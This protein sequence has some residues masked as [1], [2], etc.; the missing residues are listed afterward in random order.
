MYPFS[1]GLRIDSSPK[2]LHFSSSGPIHTCL[3]RSLATQFGMTWQSWKFGSGWTK[4]AL[5]VKAPL[6]MTKVASLTCL[7]S[8]ALP[9]E[10][11]STMILSLK[12][13]S[14][15][16][17]KGHLPPCTAFTREA[18]IPCFVPSRISSTRTFVRA[19]LRV[20]LLVQLDRSFSHAKSS[21]LLSLP[22]PNPPNP[23]NAPSQPMR[24]TRSVDRHNLTAAPCVERRAHAMSRI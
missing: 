19:M 3:S 2:S 6:S 24:D 22:P 7:P 17:T 9:R 10:G 13:V 23:P 14:T 18:F 1:I 8:G 5:M 16:C 15:W 21:Q 11:I 4:P 12:Q 20:Q